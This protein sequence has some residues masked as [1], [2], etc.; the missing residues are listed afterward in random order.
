M[1]SFFSHKCSFKYRQTSFIMEVIRNRKKIFQVISIAKLKY[2]EDDVVGKGLSTHPGYILIVQT[3]KRH[4]VAQLVD[5]N[6]HD[7]QQ[8]TDKFLEWRFMLH[9]DISNQKIHP[10]T[11]VE[12]VLPWKFHKLP[13]CCPFLTYN[14]Q[15]QPN[16][17]LSVNV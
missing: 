5:T 8:P 1:S 13:N 6:M 16:L 10:M 4:Y 2:K 11:I 12:L 14:I 3:D 9:C 15:G 17:P 7:S